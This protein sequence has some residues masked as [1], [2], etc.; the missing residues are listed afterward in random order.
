MPVED[1]GAYAHMAEELS[2]LEKEYEVLKEAYHNAQE[3]L[4]QQKQLVSNSQ[5][6]Y[7]FGNFQNT[8]NDFQQR[9]W[10]PNS[11]ENALKGLSGGNADRYQQLLKD[12]QN[13]HPTL[14]SSDFEK[15][16]STDLSK[17]YQQDIQTN[18]AAS[19]NAT[20]AF[21]DIE[22]ALKNVHEL[23]M[24]IEKSPN[25]KSSLDLNARLMAEMAYIQIQEL[26]MQAILNQQMAQQSAD[27]ISSATL[28]AKFNRLP[29]QN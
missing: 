19:V 4:N 29:D 10:S 12:Y 5:G 27:R 11:W 9:N 2:Q 15:G 7:G 3:Q 25:T 14:S 21:N 1:F 22:Q 23:S 18:Q 17:R 16:A 13:N 28:A 20:Y 26:K 24:Q 8:N 6:H